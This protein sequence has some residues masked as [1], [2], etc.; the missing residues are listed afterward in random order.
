MNLRQKN[1]LELVQYLVINTDL[2]MPPGKISAQT[3][4]AIDKVAHNMMW[5][6]IGSHFSDEA[7]LR[8][9]Q[10]HNGDAAKIVLRAHQKDLQ[11]LADL[12]F[13]SVIDKGYTEI[14]KNSLTCVSLGVMTRQEALPYI[15]RFQLL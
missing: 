5:L 15:K 7:Y 4:H 8:Y 2:E 14:P 6:G 1:P 13:V 12:G 11:K 9:E 10:W 3:G